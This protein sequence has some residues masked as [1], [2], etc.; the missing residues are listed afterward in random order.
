[1][2]IN[3]LVSSAKQSATQPSLFFFVKDVPDVESHYWQKFNPPSHYLQLAIPIT[4]FLF[5]MLVVLSEQA[6]INFIL[7]YKIKN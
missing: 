3:L 1:M 5:V 4:H 7:N 6:P 2:K